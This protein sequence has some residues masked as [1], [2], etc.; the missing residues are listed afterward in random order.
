MPKLIGGFGTS[1]SFKNIFVDA[2]LDYRIGGSVLNQPYQY[3]MEIG[4][5]KESLPGREGLV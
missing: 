4:N 5:I 2:T 3:M 1:V